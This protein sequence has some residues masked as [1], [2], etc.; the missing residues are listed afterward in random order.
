M[1][2]DTYIAE[3]NEL[4]STTAKCQVNNNKAG[5]SDAVLD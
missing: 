5:S 1:L 3:H 4:P 2:G